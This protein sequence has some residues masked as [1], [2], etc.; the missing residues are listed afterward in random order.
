MRAAL[1][2]GSRTHCGAPR[3]SSIRPFVCFAGRRPACSSQSRDVVVPRSALAAQQRAAQRESPRRAARKRFVASCGGVRRRVRRAA[4]CA[5]PTGRRRA[6][7]DERRFSPPI[8][9][10]AAPRRARSVEAH[11]E[12][13]RE[14]R[15]QGR[16]L[17]GHPEAAAVKARRRRQSLFASLRWRASSSLR[18][19]RCSRAGSRVRPD[20]PPVAARASL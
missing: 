1:I 3:A 4:T 15:Q 20:A 19:R 13:A 9:F 7:T 14:N 6:T 16:D 17:R 8:G 11:R 12:A 5:A 18:L 2:D 10:C